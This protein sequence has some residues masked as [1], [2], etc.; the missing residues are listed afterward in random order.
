ME[1][2]SN[3]AAAL[4]R[5]A[6]S[7]FDAIVT[8]MRM[9]GMSGAQLLEQVRLYY[10]Q[11]I[12][13][14]LSGQSDRE[15]ILRTVIPAHQYLAKPCATDVLRQKLSQALALKDLLENSTVKELISQIKAL[16]CTPD[17]YLQL[18]ETLK[19][20]ACSVADVGRIIERD[21]AMTSKILQ[22]VNSAFFGLGHHISNPAQAVFV[23]GTETVKSLVLSIGIFSQ[24]A[25]GNLSQRDI[26]WLWKH[27]IATSRMS[28]K[29]AQLEGQE[30]QTIDDCFAAGLLHDIGKL[31]LMTQR[32]FEWETIGKM[33]KS[34]N[35]TLWDAEHRV[36]GC[37]HAELGAYLLGIWGLPSAI[38]EAVAWHHNPSGSPVVQLS[39]LAVVHMADCIHAALDPCK[40]DD[41]D[42]F[43]SDF[44]ARC[45][46]KD[47]VE[48]WTRACRT[49][50]G[51]TQ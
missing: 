23:L 9:P 31:I 2:A 5:M 22:L 27:S 4:E 16:P 3:G 44:L 50:L 48:Q 36:L 11:T 1:F 14:V 41:S 47:R 35:I 51:E 32:H 17:L 46:L 7:P 26:D 49:V 38:V 10:P 13:F 15:T 37:S 8:D 40:A 20:P 24:F 12:R 30:K 43:D 18:R 28:Q 33:A 6:H 45:G 19:S 39:P 34:E 21:M 25:A 29:I 42:S